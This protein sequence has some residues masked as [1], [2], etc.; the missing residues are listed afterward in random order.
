LHSADKSPSPLASALDNKA[1]VHHLTLKEAIENTLK[2][3]V[4]IAVQRF[5]P[6]IRKQ[7]IFE[8]KSEFD[9]SVD[10]EFSLDGENVPTA[11]F[12]DES[13]LTQNYDW[14][15]SFNQKLVTGA[16]YDIRF[17]N[18]R[19]KTTSTF[20]NLSPQYSSELEMTLTQPLLKGFG[21]DNNKRNIY[22]AKND[23]S[24]SDYEF[25]SQVID[26]V[27]E[28][29]NVYWDLVF[30][31]EDLKVKQKSLE[32]A[33]DLERRVKAQV[34]VG[35]LA[36]LEILQAKSEVASR[37]ELLLGAEN[38]IDDTE[39]QIKNLLN[40]NFDSERGYRKIIPADLP[41]FNPEQRADL[42]RAIDTALSKRPDL[43]AKKVEVE[44]K[45]ILVKYN[46]NQTYPTLDLFGS[47]GL[48]GISGETSG[49]S[50]FKG[51]YDDTLSELASTDFYN[52][53]V[54]IKMSY[55]IGN[56]SARSRLAAS[57][58]EV[59]QALLDIKDLEKQI[60]VEVREAVRQ[61]KTDIKRV[62]ATR[63]ARKLAEEKLSAEEKKFEVGL[64][65]SFNILE[66]QE[67]LA[68]EQSKELKA[69]IDYNKS[70]IRLR[71]VIA[72]TLET[73]HIQMSGKKGS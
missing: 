17:D 43:Q 11:S 33:R 52:W 12:F 2:N 72:T 44:N 57:K 63:V 60:T 54:G 38:L 45:N 65:T 10:L 40:I 58:L 56:R 42:T 53:Q 20:S 46:K 70:N 67:D 3:N 27:S 13:R 69:I 26:T 61:I 59:A 51:E 9:P 50:S 41:E 48:N 35:T 73:H 7:D 71:Q 32:R 55:P 24:I 25:G 14:D 16:E 39:D 29:E 19:Q 66:F 30:S 36:P 6:K 62:Q 34:E 68:E 64:S 37:E 4:S 23:V 49:S 1:E 47:L 22:I 21:I 28:V 5:N 15:L 31:I 8:A 18:N